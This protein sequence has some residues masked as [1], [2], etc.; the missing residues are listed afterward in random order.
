MD[1]RAAMAALA[2]AAAILA[3][4]PAPEQESARD[5]QGHLVLALADLK[6]RED[7]GTGEAD[8]KQLRYL[9]FLA[10]PREKLEGFRLVLRWWLLQMSFEARPGFPEEVP[11]SQG[12]LW[13]IDLRD[14]GWSAAAWRAVALREPYFRLAG[15]AMKAEDAAALMAKLGIDQDAATLHVEGIARADWLFRE[16]IESER[17][18][19]YYDLLYS[20]QRFPARVLRRLPPRARRNF[21]ANVG[22][23]EEAYGIKDA[24]DFFRRQKI[25][26]RNGAVV[27]GHRDDPVRGSIVTR[28]NRFLEVIPLA[29]RA[30]AVATVTYDVDET[31]GEKDYIEQVPKALE[32]G[33]VKLK[34]DAQELLA[35]LPNGGQAGFLADAKGSRLEIA[36]NKFARDPNDPHDSRVRT[37]GSC[38][39]CHSTRSGF[40][41]P[42]DMVKGNAAAGVFLKIKDRAERNRIEAYFLGWE[43]DIASY[44]RPYA[45]LVKLATGWEPSKLS[46]EFA[47]FRLW[48][49]APV[50]Q[51]QAARETGLDR[52]AFRK[53]AKLSP[54]ARL[55]QLAAGLSVPRRT[56]EIDSHKDFRDT[57]L[58]AKE[59][60]HANRYPSRARPVRPVRRPAP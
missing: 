30:G 14:Y 24:R 51:E 55:A 2:L 20:R 41:E 26:P 5:C 39:V 43:D 38:V 29:I 49:D 52:P 58:I 60:N 11:G 56:W 57:Q 42:D 44:Q 32:L 25:D 12:A 54:K 33:K 37:M 36:D 7:A 59:G 19:S 17:S 1:A 4:G 22:E 34:F 27:A 35:T 53:V 3:A 31:A 46:K 18:Q 50:T 48:Y 6:R 45:G 47:A 16:T 21:P 40:I 9:S 23:W 13:A 10:V 8:L 15:D 28:N